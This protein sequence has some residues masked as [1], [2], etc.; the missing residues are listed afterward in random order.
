[1]TGG[2]VTAAGQVACQQILAA[3]QSVFSV[4]RVLLPA[5]AGG[6]DSAELLRLYLGHVER[7][8]GW[9]VRVVELADGVE[10]RLTG[11]GPVLLRF[12]RPERL[13]ENAVDITRLRIA[14]GLLVQP[15]EC[16]RGQLSF[17]V[18][19]TDRGL[20]LTTQLADYCPLLLGSRRPSILHK[21]LYRLTQAYI[22]KAVTVR[23]LRLVYRQL[24]GRRLGRGT[25]AIALRAGEKI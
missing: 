5:A 20:L 3:D 4:Q 13:R 2:A 10:F 25:V 16:D 14:G 18:E 23:F 22:H 24:T 7:V 6:I 1:M 11:H 19:P 8:T 21:W 12:A 17:M 15:R 9:L